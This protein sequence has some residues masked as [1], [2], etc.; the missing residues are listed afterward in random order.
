MSRYEAMSISSIIISAV[1]ASTIIAIIRKK[2][3]IIQEI[4]RTPL[5]RR[6]AYLIVLAAFIILAIPIYAVLNAIFL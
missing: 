4:F 3:P 1:I 2:A 6:L 5:V